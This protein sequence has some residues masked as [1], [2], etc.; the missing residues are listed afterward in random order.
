VVGQGQAQFQ[1]QVRV[2]VEEPPARRRGAD[3]EA[4]SVVKLAFNSPALGRLDLKLELR[5]ERILAEITTPAGRPHA[6]AHHGAERLR[7]KLEDA[8]L[9]PTVRVL[10]RSEP[11]DLYA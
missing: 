11:L 10:P 2:Q 6:I 3:G 4:A 5:G 8:G 1:P 9:D 7:A